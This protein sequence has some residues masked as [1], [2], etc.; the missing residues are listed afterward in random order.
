M[1]DSLN[2]RKP[3]WKMTSLDDEL[4]GRQPQYIFM[5]IMTWFEC[6]IGLDYN[7]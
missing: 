4:N 1:E 2:G 3:Q 5:S 6:Q 7:V